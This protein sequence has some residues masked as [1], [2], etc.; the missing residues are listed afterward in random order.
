MT[1]LAAVA[2]QELELVRR[3]ASQANGADAGRSW[4]L[5]PFSGPATQHAAFY[6]QENHDVTFGNTYQATS[7]EPVRRSSWRETDQDWEHPT[8]ISTGNGRDYPVRRPGGGPDATAEQERGPYADDRDTPPPMSRQRS[9]SQ[10]SQQY[11]QSA[12]SP[13]NPTQHQC[14][15]YLP[16]LVCLSQR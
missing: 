5:G 7:D 6:A 13:R 8:H 14:S 4:V 10:Q 16:C 3:R 9:A 1:E 11:A 15:M 2:N 12:R